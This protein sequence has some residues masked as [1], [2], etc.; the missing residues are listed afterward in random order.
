MDI[1]VPTETHLN[2]INPHFTHF[3]S[4]PGKKD[5]I[6]TSGWQVLKQWVHWPM[7]TIMQISSDLKCL[8][9]WVKLAADGILILFLIFLENKL[10]HFI[11]IGDNLH[12]MSKLIFWKKEKNIWQCFLLK[13]LPSILSI[14]SVN[15]SWLIFTS[16]EM[17]FCWISWVNY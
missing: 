16:P 11:Q 10:W 2:H 13:I 1:E 7:Y 4:S 15:S 6:F 3:L 14:N 17:R 8:A 5:I 12:E 9:C